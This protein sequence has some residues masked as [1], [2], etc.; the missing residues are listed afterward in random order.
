[1]FAV[2]VRNMVK[3]I[4]FIYNRPDLDVRFKPK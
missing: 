4:N 2:L 3:T 1:M